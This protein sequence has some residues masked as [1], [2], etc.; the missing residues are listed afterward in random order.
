MVSW[1]CQDWEDS[2]MGV[3]AICQWEVVPLDSG[4]RGKLN[5][6]CS[7]FW[8]I[9]LSQLLTLLYCWDTVPPPPTLLMVQFVL[10]ISMRVQKVLA[11][12]FRS[13]SSHQQGARSV[14]QLLHPSPS[15]C[16]RRLPHVLDLRVRVKGAAHIAGGRVFAAQRFRK[17]A[18]VSA[19]SLGAADTAEQRKPQTQS[20]R[21]QTA[22]MHSGFFTCF[23]HFCGYSVQKTK[24]QTDL[25]IWSDFLETR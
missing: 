2:R 3:V 17:A 7:R 23:L 25:V 6:S 14:G 15:V 18:D 5:T 12:H 20:G 22:D 1:D 21:C 9:W 4:G 24:T 10:V 19:W 13:I 16:R 8:G 11:T